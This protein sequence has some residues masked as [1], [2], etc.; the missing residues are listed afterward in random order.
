MTT[1]RSPKNVRA[2]LQKRP[3]LL[4]LQQ[5]YPAEWAIVKTELAADVGLDDPHSG[6]APPSRENAVVSAEIRRALTDAAVRKLSLA[7][8]TGVTKG[9]IRFNLV[10]GYV[11]QRLLFEHDLERKPVSLLWFR[12]LW[13][14]LWQRRRLMPLVQP[15]G[16]Y[17][18]YSRRLIRELAKLIDGRACLE[19][20]AGDGTL[21]RFLADEGVQ[22][23]ATDDHSWNRNVTYPAAVLRQD[24]ATALRAHEPQVVICSWPPPANTF[25]RDVFTTRSVRLYIVINAG[26]ELVAGNWVEYRR[27]T[28]FERTEE[29]ALSRL[30]LPPE[31]EAVI[32]V[33]RRTT[34]AG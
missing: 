11:G 29:P 8:A 28:A 13:P 7:A 25:E 32:H 1:R 27:Q 17:C 4:E 3:S 15:Q 26:L 14:L 12:L 20:A 5:A 22:I 24:A 21:S 10:N 19:I 16:I 31:L 18:F 33:F 2:W 9:K 6:L 23:T 34:P 30:V